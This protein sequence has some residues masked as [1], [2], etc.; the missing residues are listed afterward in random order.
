MKWRRVF[1]V[2][3]ILGLVFAISDFSQAHAQAQY[4]LNIEGV[5]WNHSTISV[6]I[7]PPGSE[8]WWM[9]SYLNDTLRAIG[10]WDH[11]IFD[12]ASNY[13]T[14]AY[15]SSLRLVPTVSQ[16]MNS[17]FD[18]YISWTETSLNA[19][20]D[21]IGLTRIWYDSSGIITNSTISLASKEFSGYVLNDV[22]MQNVALHELGHSL[23]IGHTNYSCDVMYPEYTPKKAVE[24]LS[25]L[26]VYG[27]S[28]VFQWMSKPAQFDPADRPQASPVYL[29]SSIPYQ[30]LPISYENLPPSTSSAISSPY[31]NVLAY[32]QALLTYVLQFITRPEF[33]IPLIIAVSALLVTEILFTRV[34]TPKNY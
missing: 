13:S 6:L 32:I 23:G 20:S 31:Q 10:E 11:A 16:V 4:Y 27:V 34:K 18:V 26:D 19:S 17:G 28:T 30:Y 12:F 2:L 24:G 33:L 21:E 22:D 15:L 8:S 5:M 25:T 7:V 9:P 29:P 14:F 1:A 3:L